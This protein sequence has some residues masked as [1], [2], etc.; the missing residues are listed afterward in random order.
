MVAVR[1][2]LATHL[3]DSPLPIGN[4][5]VTPPTGVAPVPGPSR[6]SLGVGGAQ[7][8]S[9][10]KAPGKPRTL[11]QTLPPCPLGAARW[12]GGSRDTALGR[13]TAPRAWKTL[14][15]TKA[16]WRCASRRIPRRVRYSDRWAFHGMLRL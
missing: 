2:Y 4:R 16:A 10:S 8:G 5:L 13:T 1:K 11:I 9:F 6:R 14:V 3:C 12:Q 15:R 7:Q